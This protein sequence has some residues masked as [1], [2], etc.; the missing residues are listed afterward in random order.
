M[1]NWLHRFACPWIDINWNYWWSKVL[2]LDFHNRGPNRKS[3]ILTCL[4][5]QN[6]PSL[7]ILTFIDHRSWNCFLLPTPKHCCH[8]FI[9]QWEGE[10]VRS[11]KITPGCT[12]K[13]S[14]RRKVMIHSIWNEIELQLIPTS[15][16]T[17]EAF[18]WGE[19]VRGLLSISTWLSASAY[20]G[21]LAGLYSFGLFVSHPF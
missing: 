1:L 17:Q 2:V 14:W 11:Y 6:S 8:V 9:P 4:K 3:R 12:I 10:S 20:F 18:S 19:V 5:R 21:I 15:T 7:K 13:I 16:A